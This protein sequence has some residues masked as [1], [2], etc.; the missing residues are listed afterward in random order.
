M[1][2]LGVD[3]VAAHLGVSARRVRNMLAH[4][5]LHGR[6]LGGQW[7]I[8]PTSLPA[9]P[10]GPGQP[11][12]PRTA[13]GL[14]AISH[15]QHPHDLTPSEISRLRRRWRELVHEG[16]PLPKLR[17]LLA[18]RA[19]RLTYAAP[20]LPGVLDDDRLARSGRSDRR[21]GMADNRLAEGYVASV[22]LDNL[23]IDHLLTP[24]ELGQTGN[25]VLYV[26]PH[27]VQ[28]PVP[29]LLVAADLADGGP[30]EAQ[31]AAALIRS[32]LQP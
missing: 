27:R 2:L 14:V 10:R 23:I 21:S 15:G 16:L 29:W 28:A 13:W 24:Q 31:Q 22:D 9:I 30:R 8:D 4:G 1:P 12:T 32:E 5:H 17:S 18:R 25:V 19:R 6:M 3:E 20:D 7:L 11:L 26:A